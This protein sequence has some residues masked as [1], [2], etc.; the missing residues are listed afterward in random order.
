[1]H[2][3][4]PEPGYPFPWALYAWIEGEEVSSASVT[5]W[6]RYAEDLANIVCSLHTIDLM[7][8]T[9]SGDL[10]WYRVG[11]LLPDE[12]WIGPRFNAAQRHDLDVDF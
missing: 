5:D 1:M 2:L 3:G 9:R 7:G 8:A 10:C 11:N 12:D 6:A 4:G